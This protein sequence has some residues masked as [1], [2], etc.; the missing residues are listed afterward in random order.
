MYISQLG[1]TR[2]LAGKKRAT[3]RQGGKNRIA[4][5]GSQA[6]TTGGYVPEREQG[7]WQRVV[8]KIP[9][10]DA[11]IRQTVK[12]MIE[13]ANRD[14][15]SPEVKKIAQ[16]FSGTDLEK[17]EAAFRYVVKNVP[18]RDDPD[19]YELLI[20]P[21]YSLTQSTGGDCD[22]QMMALAAILKAMGYDCAF[23]ILAWRSNSFTHVNV[24]CKVPSMGRWLALDPVMKGSGYG[25][26]KVPVLREELYRV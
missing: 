15:N 24:R 25:K 16:K 11:G 17:I 21:K 9:D 10:G 12:H 4:G 23:R 18:Y 7:Q 22:D 2:G 14:A 8:N 26:E 1:Y 19:D 20:A 6:A 13:L 5:V 3:R